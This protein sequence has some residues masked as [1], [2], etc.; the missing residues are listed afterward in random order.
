M[1]KQTENAEDLLVM[2]TERAKGI[3]G[4]Q[5]P[6]RIEERI[7][8]EVDILNDLGL[9]DEYLIL[10]GMMDEVAPDPLDKLNVGVRD[11][12]GALLVSY[13]CGLSSYNPMEYMGG[14]LYP[15]FYHE[16]LKERFSSGIIPSVSLDVSD[17]IYNNLLS[18]SKD[19]PDQAY[20]KPTGNLT[21]LDTLHNA[22]GAYYFP[23]IDEWDGSDDE[24]EGN[25]R[26]ALGDN[27][28]FWDY[29]PLVKDNRIIR[30]LSGMF[31]INKVYDLSKMVGI[32]KGTGTWIGYVEN[33]VRS[34]TEDGRG[35]GI[36]DDMFISCAEDIYDYLD[37]IGI[38]VNPGYGVYREEEYEEVGKQTALDISLRA[39]KGACNDIDINIL[40]RTYFGSDYVESVKRIRYLIDRPA[41]V[42]GAIEIKRLAYYWN[43]DRKT[44]ME[45]FEDLQRRKGC[46][47]QP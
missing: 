5:L 14:C 18:L 8:E 40:N 16:I 22:T 6:S 2:C 34:R 17:R 25:V 19:F 27:R 4:K 26:K 20:V 38:Q 39:R 42:R 11:G 30:A 43:K 12:A 24:D 9:D 23:I 29:V 41:C 33:H 37:R 21:L 36:G 7:K 31:G 45:T 10:A 47:C 44:Y 15:E 46:G 35:F 13:L 28:A 32:A 1:K 3:Y